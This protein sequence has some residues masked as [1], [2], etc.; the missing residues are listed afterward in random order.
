MHRDVE[1]FLPTATSVGGVDGRR[2]LD[3][4]YIFPAVDGVIF[5]SDSDNFDITRRAV[6][7][8]PE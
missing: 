4:R 3:D 7:T 6:S 8:H 5:G 1:C 2:L